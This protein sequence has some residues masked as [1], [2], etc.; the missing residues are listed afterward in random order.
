MRAHRLSMSKM[1]LAHVCAYGFRPDVE[2]FPRPSG[3]EARVGSLVHSMAE[4]HVKGKPMPTSGDPAELEKATELFSAPVKAYLDSTKWTACEIGLQYDAA[5]D[6]TAIGP[7]R[8]EPGYGEVAPTVLSGTLD[9]VHVEGDLVTVIDLK[10]GKIVDD[11][12]QLRAQA[13]AASRLY[14]AKRARVGYL[15]ARKTKCDEP[16]WTEFDEDALDVEAGRIARLL[17]VLPTSE[18]VPGDRHCWRCDARPGCPAYGAAQ[19]EGSAS[20][21]E[22][23][24][25][26]A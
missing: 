7:R 16:K 4:A 15:Y 9:L 11:T 20:E 12:E 1:S 25:F 3:P 14:K 19:A 23:A 18:P 22:A 21:L 6:A 26:F 5:N 2:V 17:R 13:V 8:G 10:S 24:G